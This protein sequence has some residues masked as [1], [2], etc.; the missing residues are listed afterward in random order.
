MDWVMNNLP[1]VVAWVVIGWILYARVVKPKMLGI[2]K[3]TAGEYP[4]F[5]EAHTLVDVRSRGEWNSGRPANAVHIPLNELAQKM[6][7]IPK[8]KPVVVICASGMR[9]AMAAS[10][11]V[12]AG[13][14]DV[15]NFAGG[16][17]SWCAAGLPRA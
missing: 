13:Y 7:K 9:S 2:K 17:G 8:N 6:G 15:Y 1:L 12:K 4:N 16:F 3:M 5:E 14:G 11:L 10:M